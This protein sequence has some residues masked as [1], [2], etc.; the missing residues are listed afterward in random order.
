VGWSMDSRMTSD[1]VVSA[2]NMALTARMPMA[3]L[4]HHSDRGVQYAAK[5]FQKLLKA[6]EIECSMSR[7]GNCYDNAVQESFYHT[8]KTELVY[9]EHYQTR[10]EAKASIFDYIEVFYNRERLHS[11]LGYMSP[12]QF[13]AEFAGKQRIA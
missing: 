2:L 8:L 9:H 7:K 10:D 4:I 1:L 13:E 6:N 5:P 11:A 12:L 3:G